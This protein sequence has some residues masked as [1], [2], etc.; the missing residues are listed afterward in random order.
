[1][2]LPLGNYKAIESNLFVKMEVEYYKSTPASTPTSVVLKFSD[3][4][5]PHTI[6]S[7][8]YTGLGKLMSITSSTSE[9]RPSANEFTVTISG[10]PN[11]SIAE[12]INSRIKGSLVTVYRG[13]F[14]ANTGQFLSGVT[15]NPII[16]FKGYVN[17]IGLDEEYDV[18]NRNSTNTITIICNNIIDVF[19]NK[20]SGRRTNPSSQKKFYP[21][22][23][24]MDR[25]PNL[26]NT[27]FDFGARK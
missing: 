16:R 15:G 19:E 24:S 10:I 21:S 6:G 27:T 22:D 3:R 13:L 12:I 2:T 11:T 20:I 14:D 25:V 7:D 17:N 9:L 8:T 4:L 18:E 26:E 1:M 23:I 5:Y